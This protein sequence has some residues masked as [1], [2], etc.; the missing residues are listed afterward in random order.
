MWRGRGGGG[1]GKVEEGEFVGAEDEVTEVLAGLLAW[2]VAVGRHRARVAQGGG[3][4]EKLNGLI[5]LALLSR[6]KG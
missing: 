2:V 1:E 3:A 6:L 4:V 5:F